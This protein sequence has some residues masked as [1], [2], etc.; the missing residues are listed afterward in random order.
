MRV[1]VSGAL[2]SDLVSFW[3]FATISLCI[4][5]LCNQLED[6]P[7]PMV[8]QTRAERMGIASVE[9]TAS[10]KATSAISQPRGERALQEVRNIVDRGNGII[11]DARPEVFHRSAHIPG[12]LSLPRDD[13][14]ASYG[15]LRQRLEKDKNQELVV[16]CAGSSCEDSRMVQ[17]A[18]IKMGYTKV[19]VFRG[20][21]SEWSA[22]GLPEEKAP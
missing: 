9:N 6:K 17:T 14:Q 11:L 18:L 2:V 12:A 7:L 20:G 15:K 21:W 5:L 3:I 19:A 16:Y 4:G 1:K 10:P 8:Y 22:A 13:F